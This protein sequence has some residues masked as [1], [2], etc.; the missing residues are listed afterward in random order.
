MS[1]GA[2]CFSRTIDVRCRTVVTYRYSR[3]HDCNTCIEAAHA[4]TPVTNPICH[5]TPAASG[6]VPA[7]A[8]VNPN[9]P[10][11]RTV[12]AHRSSCTRGGP[13]VPYFN[14]RNP[15]CGTL[16]RRCGR[17]GAPTGSGALAGFRH[18]AGPARLLERPRPRYG[19]ILRGSAR[20][21]PAATDPFGPSV[22]R[23]R[24]RVG[25]AEL[26]SPGVGRCLRSGGG[27]KRGIGCAHAASV[28]NHGDPDS[29]VHGS[30]CHEGLVVQS[31]STREGWHRHRN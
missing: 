30:R 6:R 19:H 20:A 2:L 31:S 9:A 8:C 16:S 5:R 28:D 3:V 1:A 10:R 23:E 17:R 25:G 18:N 7:A 26:G 29:V 24:S 15:V 4:D 22:P 27:T 11:A 13:Y 21:R 12:H 14:S